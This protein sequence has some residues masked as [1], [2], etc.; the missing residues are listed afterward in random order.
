MLSTHSEF[1][2]ESVSDKEHHQSIFIE[3]SQG[4]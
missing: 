1:E 4:T 3:H 2:P